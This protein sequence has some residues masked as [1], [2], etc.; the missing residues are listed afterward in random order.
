MTVL[1]RA[2]IV[3]GGDSKMFLTHFLF[4]LFFALL[5]TAVFS[6]LFQIRGPWAS[7]PLFF[8]VV[9]LSTWAIGA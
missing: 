6:G 4:A 3:T 9:F 7:I 2:P 1:N 8:I 5:L